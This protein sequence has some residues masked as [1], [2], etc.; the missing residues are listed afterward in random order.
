MSAV[1]QFVAVDDGTRFFV[2][3]VG[4]SG[5]AV[6]LPN[7]LYYFDHL[8]SMVGHGSVLAYDLR[9]RG[10]TQSREASGAATRGVEQDVEDLEALRSALDLHPSVQPWR[11][12]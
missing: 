12:L 2:R 3:R 11:E 1:E 7:G 5:D 4:D 9:H 6:V 10:H 8:R